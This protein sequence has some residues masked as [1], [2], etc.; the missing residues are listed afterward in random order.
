M[1]LP[2]NSGRLTTG[3]GTRRSSSVY[4]PAMKY[5]TA[6]RDGVVMFATFPRTLLTGTPK[7]EPLFPTC[8]DKAV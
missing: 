6:R 1:L 7:G 8:A 3:Y 5:P 4:S 2:A